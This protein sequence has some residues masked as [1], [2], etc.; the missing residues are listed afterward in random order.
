MYCPG[1]DTPAPTGNRAKVSHIAA[2]MIAIKS[3]L[4]NILEPDCNGFSKPF[5]RKRRITAKQGV[6][7]YISA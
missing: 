3:G 5:L 4:F 1:A 6:N 7:N 2:F